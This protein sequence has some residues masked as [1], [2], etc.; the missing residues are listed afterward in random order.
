ML[1][2]DD[3]LNIMRDAIGGLL[4]ALCDILTVTHTSDGQG[5][6]V[7]TWGTAVAGVSCRLDWRRGDEQVFGNRLFPYTGWILSIPFDTTIS[8]TQ[9][10]QL[11]GIVYNV[12]MVDNNKS[13]NA[14]LRCALE[15]VS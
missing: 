13:W 12:S 5:G 7:D 6:A 9:R 11:G 4:P 8:E 3:D 14:V 2:T 10:V 15:E 1:L